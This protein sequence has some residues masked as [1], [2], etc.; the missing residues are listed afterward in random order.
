M[1]R[2]SV[3]VVAGLVLAAGAAA[4]QDLRLVDAVAGQDAQSAYV[5][6][7]AGVDANASRADGAT[8]LLW[9]AHWDDPELAA[10]LIR[11]GADV[12]AADDHG[13]TP[14]ERAAENASLPMV[15]RL[16]AAGARA[17]GRPHERPDPADD[18]GADRQRGRGRGPAGARG[19]RRRGDPRDPEHGPD[20]GG[21][22][23]AS[24]GGAR[25][26][27][28]PGP[29]PTRPPPRGSRRCSTRPATV[30]WRWPR[31]CSRPAS[32]RTRP[33][34]T[35]PRPALCDRLGPRQL[36]APAARARRRPERD[37]GRGAGPARRP[38]AAS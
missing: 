22:G 18:G 7:D 35:H 20:V 13:V 33:G 17:D 11:A 24:R 21:R 6:L 32:T 34:P 3:T 36:C 37:D 2:V 31:R 15:E 5:L 4:G 27:S 25:A 9:A 16:L 26:L 19:R 29:T 30:T 14:L 38:P 8:A 23:G 28:M 10:R 1:Q 12:N